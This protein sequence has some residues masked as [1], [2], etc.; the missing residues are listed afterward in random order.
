MLL[1]QCGSCCCSSSGC[2][3]LAAR[4]NSICVFFCMISIFCCSSSCRRC[5]ARSCFSSS[6][7][8][9]SG[10]VSA[11]CCI[12]C[13]SR[14]GGWRRV[15]FSWS[16][17]A[18]TTLSNGMVN[19]CEAAA[20]TVY[21]LQKGLAKC[22][23]LHLRY[24]CPGLSVIL[25]LSFAVSSIAVVDLEL[26]QPMPRRISLK[27]PFNAAESLL[28]LLSGITW[29][30]LDAVATA[31]ANVIYWRAALAASVELLSPPSLFNFRFGQLPVLKSLDAAR[32][33][34]LILS[35]FRV[36]HGAQVT[37]KD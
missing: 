18:S 6:S 22:G 32:A 17:A 25:Q 21:W 27:L 20:R 23:W 19:A 28:W 7:A 30:A 2:S 29:C 12:S 31:N 13:C 14:R 8:S 4:I 33:L 3:S 36:I 11:A 35:A 15:S 24:S 9:V 1:L 16:F 34:I 26:E 37:G 10:S 5:S